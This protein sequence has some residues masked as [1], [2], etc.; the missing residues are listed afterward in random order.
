MEKKGQILI[1]F[2]EAVADKLRVYSN[3]LNVPIN[4]IVS[5]IVEDSLDVWAAKKTV[6]MAKNFATII[7]KNNLDGRNSPDDPS[8]KARIAQINKKFE[9]MFGEMT[10]LFT[11]PQPPSSPQGH[12]SPARKPSKRGKQ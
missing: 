9:E 12:A 6:Q 4:E 2:P 10:M 11:Q 7:A 5:S 1:R 3:E 8:G